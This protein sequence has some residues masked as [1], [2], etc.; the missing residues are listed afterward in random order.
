MLL[1][2]TLSPSKDNASSVSPVVPVAFFLVALLGMVQLLLHF[3]KSHVAKTINSQAPY[4][5][6][7]G[8]TKVFWDRVESQVERITER[9]YKS[10]IEDIASRVYHYRIR[11]S[12]EVEYPRYLYL[13]HTDKKG[14]LIP[15]L[16][17][18]DIFDQR[19][20]WFSTDVR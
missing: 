16:V 14:R 8:A 18:P 2:T 9:T 20:K 12:S 17:F 1:R 4:Y 3:E 13:G 6:S 5:N 10:G 19:E 11:T 7:F 15:K